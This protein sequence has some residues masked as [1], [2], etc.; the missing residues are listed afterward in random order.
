MARTARQSRP[1]LVCVLADDSGSMLGEKAKAATRG[2]REMLMQ[3]QCRGPRGR[4]RSYFRFVLIPFGS[5]AAIHPLCDMKPVREIN[6]D[7][8]EV[9]GG[10]GGTNITAALELALDG[11][12]PYMQKLQNHSERSEHPLPLVLLFSDGYDGPGDSLS[13]AKRIRK[14]NIDGSP[15]IIATAGVSIDGSDN[16]NEQLLRDLASSPA[17]YAHISSTAG[18]TE[19]L[20]TVG[21]CAASSVAELERSVSS[22]HQP[23][24]ITQ[25]GGT[26]LTSPGSGAAFGVGDMGGTSHGQG[27]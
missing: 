14:L 8:I 13:A 15:V 1:Q 18:L 3:C 27:D 17:C 5:L 25:A 21:S 11:L 24:R 9:I 16:C 20:A 26:A 2:I 12:E 10:S 23:R 19:F 22:V 4:D 7:A 6:P